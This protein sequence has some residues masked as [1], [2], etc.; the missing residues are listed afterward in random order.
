MSR[1]FVKEDGAEP[2]PPRFGLPDPADPSYPAAAARAL[3]EGARIGET[4]AA[5]SATGFPWGDERLVDEVR[6]I[7]DEAVDS[8]DDRLEQV[9]D[10]YLRRAGFP[11]G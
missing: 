6:R 9:A 4:T 8:G 1:A 2:P 11:A 5:E 7:R 10:R 3:L